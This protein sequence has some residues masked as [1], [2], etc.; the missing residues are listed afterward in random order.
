[1]RRIGVCR[2]VAA[3]KM[4][5]NIPVRIQARID[6]VRE[7]RAALAASMGLRADYV[8]SLYEIIIEETCATEEREMAAHGVTPA[9]EVAA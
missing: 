7:G 3:F 2:R 9:I 8:R 1:V 5:R 4:P 6:A